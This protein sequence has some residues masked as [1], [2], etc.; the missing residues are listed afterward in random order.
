MCKVLFSGGRLSQAHLASALSDATTVWGVPAAKALLF[1]DSDYV[2]PR[3]LVTEKLMAF[4]AFKDQKKEAMAQAT[5]VAK[6][7]KEQAKGQAKTKEQKRA[8]AAAEKAAAAAKGAPG[9]AAAK[10]AFALG[11]VNN[12]LFAK[13]V[14]YV[15]ALVASAAGSGSWIVVDRV[16]SLSPAMELL[17]DAALAGIPPEHRPPVL[18]VDSIQRL[19]KHLLDTPEVTQ[20]C[21]DDLERLKATA[22]PLPAAGAAAPP[23]AAAA[24]PS[25]AEAKGAA[26]APHEEPL[27][28][29]EFYATEMFL[30][31]RLHVLKKPPC[32]PEP[33]HMLAQ[34]QG[35]RLDPRVVWAYHYTRTLFNGGSLY[36]VFDE[37]ECAPDLRQ[38]SLV[39][40]A[41]FCANGECAPWCERLKRLIKGGSPV[42]MLHNTGGV[43]QAFASLRA[44]M[45]DEGRGAAASK[46]D[47]SKARQAL[48]G[49]IEIVDAAQPWTTQFGMPEIS[50]MQ[51]LQTAKPTTLST[52]VVSCDALGET[53][54]AF[55][56]RLT[57][58]L[59]GQ[60]YAHLAAAAAMGKTPSRTPR[61]HR[62]PRSPVHCAH[63]V[64]G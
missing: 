56:G 24:A 36:L 40:T 60:N 44:A 5:M 42:L 49:R 59:L 55:V 43:T 19:K 46:K 22:T 47:P 14:S 7:A 16:R 45:L 50:M 18:V 20:K 17:L 63:S 15:A 48:L 51:E 30:E 52:R 57:A 32:R 37:D 29:P 62:S 38:Q 26:E 31:P 4:E 23:A 35:K 10:D 6:Q 8:A 9:S 13:L 34:G 61:A 12:V 3:E 33:A 25:E 27:T 64:H 39:R 41:T 53:P 11:I 58:C 28:L 2:H 1:A 21:L 54:D